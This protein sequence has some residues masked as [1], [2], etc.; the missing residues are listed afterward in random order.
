MIKIEYNVEDIR[1]SLG[2]VKIVEAKSPLEAAKKVFPDCKI[3][4]S[5]SGYYDIVVGRYT[6]QYYGKGYRTY[7]Y[8]IE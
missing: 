8:I 3:T 7:G 4:R 5:Y 2:K 1:Y 6:N